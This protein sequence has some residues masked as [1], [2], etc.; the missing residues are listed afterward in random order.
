MT[1]SKKMDALSLQGA[2]FAVT[3]NGSPFVTG[4]TPVIKQGD[5]TTI[6]LQADGVFVQGDL[7]TIQY[8]AGSIKSA[9]GGI[10]APF[11]PVDAC[12]WVSNPAVN[13][14]GR[15]DADGFSD[16]AGV[17]VGATLDSD[18]G[19]DL[20]GLDVGD[21]VE[22]LI[23][24]PTPGYYFLSLRSTSQST[25]GMVALS[26]SGRSIGS[27]VVPVT[28][29]W[30]TYSTQRQLVSLSGGLQTLRLDVQ[31][32]GFRLHWLAIE[33]LSAVEDEKTT[34]PLA[35]SLGQNYP[36]PFNPKTGV[37]FQVSGVSD[38]KL[39]V[40]DLLGREVAVLVNE[41][42]NPGFYEVSFDGSGLASGAYIYRLRAGAFR[43]TRTMLLLK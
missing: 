29:S 26:N 6:V 16:M 43:Q 24:V 25:Q 15:I 9:D 4:L 39:T 41:R 28:G 35:S 40:Y 30:G 8:T 22:Y 14:P 33:N 36:N 12:N 7:V 10:L 38:V 32:G 27:S 2:A 5:S 31:T 20:T 13:V 23:K 17:Q 11:G 34:L 19:M 21:W 37:R 3:K 42:K 1:F 18:G